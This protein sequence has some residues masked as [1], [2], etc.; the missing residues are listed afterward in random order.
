MRTRSAHFPR[1]F[2]K[3]YPI[4]V[5]GEGAYLFD[6]AG[7]KYLDF[8][9]SAV[10]SFIGHGN[11]HI[12]SAIREQ[13]ERLEFA[14]TTQFVS[15][16]ALALADE[17]LR[18]AGPNFAGGAVFFTSGGSEAVE[19]ALKLARQYQ[20]EIGQSQRHRI[21]SRQQA[22]HGATLGAMA[23]SGNKQRRDIYLPMLKSDLQ[24]NTPY[25][26]RCVY[27]C[28]D[29]AT[30]Y[31]KEVEAALDQM[32]KEAAAM[33]LEPISGATLGAVA[34]PDGYLPRVADACS[35][36][37]VL[38]IADEVMTGFGRTGRNFAVDHW[39]VAPDIMVVGKGSAS[40]YAP[41]GAVIASAKVVDAIANGSGNLIH[42]FTYNS[43]PVSTAAGL[44]VLG[45]MKDQKLLDRATSL[46]Q[47]LG[48]ELEQ[49]KDCDS[50]GDVRGRGLLWAV[51]FV[52]D[53]ETKQ[54]F[55]R[56][57]AFAPKVAAATAS[58]GVLVYPMQ[59]CVDGTL[60]DHILIAPPAII[61]E[62]EIYHAVE[63]LRDAIRETEQNR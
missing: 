14:H 60:G 7:K 43:H 62:F 51:E 48:K 4:V 20:V 46:G 12:A 32:G 41:L 40:G 29:C 56:R 3:P 5:R 15:E 8:H 49:L 30:N 36:R 45:E 1:S 23:V 57:D 21:L 10:V 27:G 17:V 47:T 9:S 61:T 19:S 6:S 18:F 34:P 11:Q 55:P 63:T 26:Y 24:V 13:L 44:A 31:A 52:A 58:R 33:I 38:F 59:G 50:V 25:C 28:S 37:G 2:L 35:R 22:Y 53:G 39:G 54:A 42:G 16:P